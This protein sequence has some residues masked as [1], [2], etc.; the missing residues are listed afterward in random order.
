MGGSDG[1]WHLTISQDVLDL[2]D[3]A[4]Y[5]HGDLPTDINKLLANLLI[6]KFKSEF[7]EV[8]VPRRSF[9]PIRFR[10]TGKSS[11]S[12]ETT[13]RQVEIRLSLELEKILSK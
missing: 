13:R 9:Y 1:V 5:F 11:L 8:N 6:T 10:Y 4:I 2:T 3:W 7:A 12:D